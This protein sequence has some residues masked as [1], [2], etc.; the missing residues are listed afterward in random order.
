MCLVLIGV[1]AFLSGYQEAR[2]EPCT[3]LTVYTYTIETTVT[4][5]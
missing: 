1:I 2:N 4:G 3:L 5:S